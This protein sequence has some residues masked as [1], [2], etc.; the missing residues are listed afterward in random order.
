M[1]STIYFFQTVNKVFKY[2]FRGSNS[3]TFLFTSV[4]VVD[5]H[6]EQK[7]ICSCRR[8]LFPLQVNPF[9]EGLCPTG[10][11]QADATFAPVCIYGKKK[12]KTKHNGVSQHLKLFYIILE[13]EL[14]SIYQLDGQ[15]M[16]AFFDVW[17][18]ENKFYAKVSKR[19]YGEFVYKSS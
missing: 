11:K 3:N 10:N 13:W 7:R 14:Q 17:Q 12:T 9:L 18:D 8:K 15:Y 6:F 2:T 16:K 19:F 4:F 5:W 1:F